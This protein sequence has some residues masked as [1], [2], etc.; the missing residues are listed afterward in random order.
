MDFSLSPILYLFSEFMQITCQFQQIYQFINRF[1][2][3]PLTNE[4]KM[5]SKF[6]EL[7]T[8]RLSGIQIVS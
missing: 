5:E 6:Q 4:Y 8:E 3:F 2:R 1:M 7:F